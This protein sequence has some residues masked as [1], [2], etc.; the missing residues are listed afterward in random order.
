MEMIL[1][2]EPKPAEAMHRLG[3]VNS[4]VEP[5]ATLEEALRLAA[6]IVRNGPLAV[7]ASKEIA[8]RSAAE[9]WTDAEGWEKQAAIVAPVRKSAD[10]QEGLR[11]FAEKRD[12]V[13]T[14][15]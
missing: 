11:A 4:M 13:W 5:G 14:G 10:M 1:T 7:R 6:L 8:A 2:A 12:P 3:Y 15:A 9:Q